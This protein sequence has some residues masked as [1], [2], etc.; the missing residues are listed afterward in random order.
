MTHRVIFLHSLSHFL[1]S[2]LPPYVQS[3]TKSCKFL[4]MCPTHHSFLP[5]LILPYLRSPLLFTRT[6]PRGF[7]V[8]CLQFHNSL[9]SLHNAIKNTNLSP[10]M[11]SMLHSKA[12]R[13]PGFL[14]S[15]KSYYSSRLKA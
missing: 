7:K 4:K 6:I 14:S 12:Q 8:P 11:K 2:F 5:L 10:R 13:A 9:I 15:L 3:V 1:H